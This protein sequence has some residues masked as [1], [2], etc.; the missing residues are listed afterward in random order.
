MT[1]MLREEVVKRVHRQ[2]NSLVMVVP[3]VLRKML[4]IKQ[5]DHVYF[6]WVRGRKSVRFGKVHLRKEPPSGR[7]K[8]TNN[9]YQRR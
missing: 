3:M 6:T 9:E 5:G 8:H 4:D 1:S 2:H 7:A